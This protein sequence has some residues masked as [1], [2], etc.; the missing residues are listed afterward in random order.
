MKKGVFGNKEKPL[1]SL[2]GEEVKAPP[3]PKRMTIKEAANGGFIVSMEGGET[4]ANGH[5]FDDKQHV[6]SKPEEVISMFEKHFDC[7]DSEK[8]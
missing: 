3:M 8:E 5:F 7:G 2:R 6:A 1:D 4:G